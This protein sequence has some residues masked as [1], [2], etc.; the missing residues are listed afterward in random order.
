MQLQTNIKS[1]KSTKNKL[2]D[3]MRRY[4]AIVEDDSI[5]ITYAK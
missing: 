4:N 3:S 5:Q 1:I 2:D